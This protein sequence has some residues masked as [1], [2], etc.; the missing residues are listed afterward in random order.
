M[1]LDALRAALPDHAKDIRLNLGSVIG[2]STLPAQRLWGAVLAC[3][4]MSRNEVVLRELAE[5]AR[6]HLDEKAFTA[7]KSAASI[8]AMTT[9]YCRGRHMLGDAEYTTMPAKLRMQ[10]IA[11]HGV[12]KADFEFWSLAAASVAGCEVCVESH[13]RVLRDHGADR[14]VVLDAVRIAAVVNAAAVTEAA[15]RALA[16]ALAV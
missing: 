2:N 3:A 8:M 9:V 1:S 5:D 15:E 12:D 6:A 14:E 7:A 10:A 11:N 16:D 13:G 4:I